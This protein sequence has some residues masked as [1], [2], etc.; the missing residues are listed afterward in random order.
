[1]QPTY[2]VLGP[3]RARRA[4]GTEGPVRGARLAA[5]FAALAAAGGRTVGA[6]AL[7]DRVWADGT[8]APEEPAAALQALVARLRRTLGAG[9]VVSEPGGYRLGA[10]RE[11]VDLFRFERLAA[12]GSAALAA[13]EPGRA[14]ALLDEALGLWSGPALA[15]LPDRAADPLVV[16]VE[17]R[18]ADARRARL[19]AG[20]ALGRAAEVL[21]ELTALCADRPLDE[22]VQVLRLRALRE[23]GRAAEALAGYEE[24]RRVLADR[25]GADPGPELRALHQELLA[26]TRPEAPARREPALP[27]RLT[28]FIGR[29]EELSSLS[30][31]LASARLVTLLGPGG[32]GKTR[33][34]L[35]AAEAYDGEGIVRLAELAAVREE[36]EVPG[37]VLTALGARETMLRGSDGLLGG[38]PLSRLVEHC[39]GR[40][41]L[42]LLDNCEHVVGAAARLAEA[43]LARCP[44]VRVLATSRE[45]LGVPGERL[46]PLGPLPEATALRLLGERG[47]AARPGF[48]V[49]RDVAAGREVV[50][51]LDGLPLAIELAAAR[52]R[53]LSVRQIAER[54]DDRFRLLTSGARTVLP[55]QQTLRAV[56]DWSW[57]LLEGPERAVLRRL[58]VFAGGCD[59][60]AAEAVC[61]GPEGAEVLDV[62]GALV[63][64]SLVVAAPGERGMRFRLLET[65]AE[66]A[67]ERLDEAGE[68]AAVER[69]HLTYYREL[70]RTQDPALRGPRQATA[71]ALFER[72]HDNLR[73]ALRTAV[74]AGE[75]QEVLC[76]VHS[77]AW[78]WQLRNHQH[79][80]RTWTAA[81]GRFGPDP[82]DPPVRPAEPFPGRCHDVPPPWTGERLREARRGVRLYALAAQGG[83]GAT[84]MEEDARVRDRLH[85]IAAAYRPG[86]P[87]TCRQPGTVWFFA[88]LMT[89]G[90]T[91]L[92]TT[93]G[94]LVDACRAD[95]DPWDLAFALLMR[96]RL[97]GEGPEEAAEALALFE[98]ARDAWGIAESLAARGEA[99]ERAGRLAEA[100]GD[101]GR[102]AAAAGE[103]GA[104]SQVPVFTARLAAVRLRLRPDGD[105]EAER[106]LVRSAEEAARWGA[107]A[108]GS[109]RLLL[110]QHYAHTGRTGLAQEQLGRAETEFGDHTP[111]L[112]WGLVGGMR[113]W[114]DC[115]D[116]A[117]DRAL[118]RLGRAVDDLETLAHLVAPYLLVAQLAT[119]A[120]ALG[121]RAG[122]GDA[123][124]GAL[125]LGAYDAHDAGGRGGGFRPYTSRTEELI[126]RGAGSAVRAGLTE[127]EYADAYAAG[128]ALPV[129]EAAA[130]LRRAAEGAGPAPGARMRGAGPDTTMASAGT[131][132]QKHGGDGMNAEP[133]EKS[134]G[135]VP[136][137]DRLLHS[138]SEGEFTAEDVVLASGRDVTPQTLAWAERRMA[139]KGRASLDELLP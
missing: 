35:E 133:D 135:D 91:G 31:E 111:A 110:A 126:R 15:D 26:G 107:E 103:A 14:A 20:L 40:R 17:R 97:A 84:A 36:S 34:A 43:V 60:E 76:L 121:G 81:A 89:G 66:Y 83:S 8:T 23:A 67:G 74:A 2:R 101:L 22:S 10:A 108:A 25:L 48:D 69:A 136:T 73:T 130:L 88:R 28:S 9:A 117:H 39:A 134:R 137:P 29:E 6:A 1:M 47:A 62:L 56:V 41:M 52:L 124:T 86:L 70:A 45:P 99:Y 127:G 122:P 92:D 46:R 4:D 102:A 58:A 59:L 118:A 104:R 82:F 98:E 125:L 12:E 24:V 112:F 49:E 3:G 131:H 44:G 100:A 72:E 71:L 65:V 116:G 42:L 109:G 57:D 90:L 79:D 5:L 95:G 96:A 16:R 75:E 68:R 21:P 61:A 138:G 38:D 132:P 94:L 119:G 13:G 85:R 139:E 19:A 87:Q 106:L 113:A 114:V 77:L 37:A 30:A 27:A 50:R 7:A 55:R 33:L 32:V 78:F 115:L 80:S 93:L 18:H 105:E 51:R 64:K 11:D 53:V 129:A 54:L 128:R 123:R 63:D 120:W